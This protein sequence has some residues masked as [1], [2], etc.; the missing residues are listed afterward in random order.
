MAK[1]I[2]ALTGIRGLAAI[3]VALLHASSY[4][5]LDNALSSSVVNIIKRGWLGVDLFFVLSGFVISYVHQSDFARLGVKE[6]ARFLKLRLARIY[7]A[8]LVST[9]LL[10]PMV[11]GAMFFSPYH[12]SDEVQESYSVE[13]L[14]YSLALLNGWGFPNSIGWNIPSWSVGSEWCAEGIFLH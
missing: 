7:P 8:H 3:W 1:Q 6:Y 9:L 4:V 11:L 10:I 14:G 12:F 2:G 5:L 13:K